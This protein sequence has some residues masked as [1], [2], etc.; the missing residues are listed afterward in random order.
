[1]DDLAEEFGAGISF[2]TLDVLAVPEASVRLPSSKPRSTGRLIRSG[3]E[4]TDGSV[5]RTDID[6]LSEGQGGAPDVGH[7]LVLGKLSSTDVMRRWAGADSAHQGA[8]GL[9]NTFIKDLKANGHVVY[10]ESAP[11]R[12]PKVS[13][14]GIE[15]WIKDAGKLGEKGGIRPTL[16]TIQSD[17]KSLLNLTKRPQLSLILLWIRCRALGPRRE[18]GCHAVARRVLTSHLI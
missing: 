5:R 14:S 17:Q 4:D 8:A 1:M 3:A 9:V 15:N 12:R 7:E 2:Y 16:G 10:N 6:I 13:A 11:T 18:R